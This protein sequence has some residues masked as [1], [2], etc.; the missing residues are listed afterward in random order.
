MATWYPG[1][2]R[3]TLCDVMNEMG[4]LSQLQAPTDKGN[5]V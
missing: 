4:V 2:V 3:K 5:K 1:E